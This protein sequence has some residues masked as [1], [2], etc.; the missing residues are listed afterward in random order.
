[1]IILSE[2]LILLALALLNGVFSGAEIAVLSVRKTRLS[3]LI[4]QKRGGAAAIA[5]LREAPER[6]FATVQIGITV[7]GAAG[8]AFGGSALTARLEPVL[9][10]VPLLEDYAHEIAF[11]LVVS[12][13]SYLSLVLG[14]LVPKSLALRAAEPYALVVG[15]LLRG[16]AWIA[17][18][19]VWFLTASSNI[20]LK[21]FGDSTS[22]TEARVSPE[23]LQQLL[24][25][26]SKS[27]AL[28]PRV[29]EIA[30]RALDFGA[31]SAADVM[32][33]RSMLVAVP[34]SVSLKKLKELILEEG[35][36]R[37]PVFEDTID[38]IVGYIYAKDVT[39]LVLESDL[40]HLDDI[41]REPTFVPGTMRAIELLQMMQAQH[42]HQVIVLEETGGV[43]GLVTMEDLVEEFVGDIFNESD[44]ADSEV[45]KKE[46]GTVVLAQGN[47]PLRD[48]DRVLGTSLGE[49]SN[50]STLA[51]LC[52]ELA[53]GVPP[54]GTRLKTADGVE[55]E[56]LAATR[57]RIQRVR[58]TSGAV[59]PKV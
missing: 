28:H 3:E 52:M 8:A 9:R 13:I 50:A 45:V 33:P 25:E 5:A 2:L 43:A 46:S 36:T 14:E 1:M 58:V 47:A 15:P 17:R 56:I 44:P 21:L 4:E 32:I 37:M 19:A 27:G 55:L 59:S 49:Q 20:V 29:S 39:A 26:A 24:E 34:K 18:P 12:F 40:I 6:F 31:L 54:R 57:Q 10:G 7:V 22:F 51:G 30:S 41:L 11:V 16:L 23:E 48:V 42:V 35:H 38:H 53:K